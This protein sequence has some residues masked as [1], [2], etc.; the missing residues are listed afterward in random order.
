M[1]ANK[2]FMVPYFNL[3]NIPV[4]ADTTGRVSSAVTIK[5]I[6]INVSIRPNPLNTLATT[7]ANV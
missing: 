7:T 3:F 1:N 2:A 4:S 6:E 5:T